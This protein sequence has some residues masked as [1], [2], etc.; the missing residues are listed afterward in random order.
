[1]CRNRS[2]KGRYHMD[3]AAPNQKKPCAYQALKGRNPAKRT[4][5]RLLRACLD[6]SA[7]GKKDPFL[8]RWGKSKHALRACTALFLSNSIKS[9]TWHNRGHSWFSK[10]EAQGV[11]WKYLRDKKKYFI[12]IPSFQFWHRICVLVS[13]SRFQKTKIYF[14]ISLK[15]FGCCEASF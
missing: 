12:S 8:T 10:V 5:F 4:W 14:L 11:C 1:M 7:G 9:M 2:P 3:W 15:S 13:T 6:F